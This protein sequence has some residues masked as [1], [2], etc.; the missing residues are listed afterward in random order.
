MNDHS[1]GD[2]AITIPAR[3][4]RAF[5]NE[6]TLR[7]Y[8]A[9]SDEIAN[10]ALRRGT[11]V[12]PPFSMTRMTW[13]KPS[14]LWMMYRSGWGFKDERQ[15]R[16]LAMDITKAGFDWA[17]AHSCESHPEAS[18]TMEAWKRIKE[19]TPVRVQWDPER[20]LHFTPLA[21]RAI[22]IGLSKEA[23]GL[24][25]NEWIQAITDVTALAHSIHDLVKIGEVEKA[26]SLLPVERPYSAAD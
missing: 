6:N 8:Q 19:Q 9:F 20:N 21:H 12:S 14:F 22:Q 4:I 24:Y 7:V 23:V 3:Q 15:T 26:S 16:I 13:I 10:S 25:V 18:V 1:F 2:P 5:Q 17:L 11:F